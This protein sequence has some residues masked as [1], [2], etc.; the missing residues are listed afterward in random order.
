MGL[1]E[2]L[3]EI[4][5]A[6][7]ADDAKRFFTRHEPAGHEEIVETERIAKVGEAMKGLDLGGA[8]SQRFTGR[9]I[10]ALA[11]DRQVLSKSGRAISS[12]A[13]ADEYGFKDVDGTLPDGPMKSRPAGIPGSQP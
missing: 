7:W 10:A 5:S 4:A 9:A 1:F 12:R 3:D 11:A 13:L 2:G 8:E 6:D